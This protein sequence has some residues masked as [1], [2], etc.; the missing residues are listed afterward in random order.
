[1]MHNEFLRMEKFTLIIKSI[2]GKLTKLASM[3]KIVER[4]K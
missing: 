2:K 4:E 1:M 3:Y